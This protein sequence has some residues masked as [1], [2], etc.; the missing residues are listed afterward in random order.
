[1]LIDEK[2]AKTILLLE[3][4]FEDTNQPK[5]IK[6]SLADKTEI[7]DGA[8]ELLST[9][10]GPVLNLSGL[11]ELS[12]PAA[13]ALGAYRG[14]LHLG[15]LEDLSPEILEE[16]AER[17]WNTNQYLGLNGLR[18]LDETQAR[19]LHSFQGKL[20]LCGI[21]EISAKCAKILGSGSAFH[22]YLDGLET[23]SASTLK[24]LLRKRHIVSLDG[25]ETLPH[26]TQIWED[27]EDNV[28]ELYLNG[29]VSASYDSLWA[30][31]TV[32]QDNL[33]LNSLEALPQQEGIF[34]NSSAIPHLGGLKKITKMDIQNFKSDIHLDGLEEIDVECARLLA[35][36]SE[37]GTLCVGLRKMSDE[38]AS[39]L[40]RSNSG[41]FIMNRLE[42]LTPHA[43]E[44]C[45]KY[46]HA[47]DIHFDGLQKISEEALDLLLADY[48]EQVEEWCH[49][50]VNLNGLTHLTPRMQ[51][52]IEET[53][54]QVSLHG[55]QV[56]S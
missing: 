31:A 55:I 37:G 49:G 50:F 26:I 8:A 17:S 4:F 35:E 32:V 47:Q 12:Q 44:V 7:T 34:E 3:S 15:G 36:A 10:K 33:Y 24:D 42:E 1:M 38:V 27:M 51:K 54:H 52:A 14:D 41:S 21:T 19:A 13:A 39:E 2:V 43:A 18:E 9:Y 48:T 56:E 22:L 11:K 16:F 40:L 20:G 25:L 46:I 53:K 28:S 29:V 6:D 30:V 23:V 45:G 5:D